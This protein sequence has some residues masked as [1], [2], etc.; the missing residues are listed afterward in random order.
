[1]KAGWYGDSNEHHTEQSWGARLERYWDGTDWTGEVRAVPSPALTSSVARP[2][3]PRRRP[4]RRLVVGGLLVLAAAVAVAA[5]LLSVPAEVA[6]VAEPRESNQETEASTHSA[7]AA[8]ESRAY[9]FGAGLAL[10]GDG[11]NPTAARCAPY[12]TA[13]QSEGPVREVWRDQGG[14]PSL[15]TDRR[16]FDE[17]CQGL[18]D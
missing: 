12:W 17:A 15:V 13:I 3:G 6:E 16:T 14:D 18:A 9:G 2:G 8:D 4:Q 5:I 1:M 10:L 11:T 7:L